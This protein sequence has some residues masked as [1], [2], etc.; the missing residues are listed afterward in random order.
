[1][2]R[3]ELKEWAQLDTRHKLARATHRIAVL[4]EGV[5]TMQT[6]LL[7]V[8]QVGRGGEWRRTEGSGGRQVRE[9]L[10]KAGAWS[11]RGGEGGERGWQRKRRIRERRGRG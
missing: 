8:V 10:S 1:M 9:K 7:G 3:S 11:G 6:T 5:L 4:T 2:A